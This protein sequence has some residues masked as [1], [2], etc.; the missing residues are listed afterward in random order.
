MNIDTGAVFETESN[1]R[2]L[3]FYDVK[4]KKCWKVSANSD[5]VEEVAIIEVVKKENKIDN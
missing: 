4:R 2:F 1:K 5:D 3:T